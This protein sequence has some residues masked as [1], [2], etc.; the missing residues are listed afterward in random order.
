MN[1]LAAQPRI[2]V[3]TTREASELLGV[4]L[5]TIQL[6]V[7][8][9]RLEAWKTPGGHRRITRSSVENLF[10]KRTQPTRR[11]CETHSEDLPPDLAPH[12][13]IGVDNTILGYDLYPIEETFTDEKW[14]TLAISKAIKEFGILGAIGT[15]ACIIP[16]GDALLTD[17]LAKSLEPE[18]LIFR[19]SPDKLSDPAIQ[20]H[21]I[22]LKQAGFRILLDLTSPGEISEN[23]LRLANFFRLDFSDAQNAPQQRSFLAPISNIAPLIGAGINDPQTLTNARQ[24][25]CQFLQGQ[26]LARR[27]HMEAPH[28]L[29]NHHAAVLNLFVTLQTDPCDHQ[30]ITRLLQQKPSLY[31]SLLRLLNSPASGLSR[32]IDSLNEILLLLGRPSL[33][34]STLLL[35]FTNPYPLSGVSNPLMQSASYRAHLME[36][37]VRLAPDRHQ[38]RDKAFLLGLLSLAPIQQTNLLKYLLLPSDI[39]LA[40]QK[41]SGFLGALLAL[42]ETLESGNSDH[43]GPLTRQLGIRR[44]ELLRGI[45]ESLGWSNA[46][47]QTD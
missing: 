44:E 18:R 33:I 17:E 28:E 27:I 46:L 35:L 34:R 15:G 12:P 4:S 5:R 41:R 20:T 29:A 10:N 16:L 32:R 21:C 47:A 24:A 45:V 11:E 36:Y 40:L 31:F 22:S 3:C 38:Y 25:G 43:V 42:A 2:S 30:E 26:D 7:D 37:L 19:L 23:I 1:P 6:W 14:G 8:A 39:R 13:I 9:K